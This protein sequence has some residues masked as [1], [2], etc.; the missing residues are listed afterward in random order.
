MTHPSLQALAS[1]LARRDIA[2]LRYQFPYM[3]R[4]SRRPDPPALCQATVRSAVAEAARLAPHLPLFAG[5]RSFGGRMSSAAQALSPLP[6]V[7]GLVFL[8]FPLHPAG[9]PGSER[10]T[11]LSKLTLPLLF[12]QGTRDALAQKALLEPLIERL[13]T[14]ASVHWLQG[15]DHGFHVAA[16]SGRTD[17]D[18]REEYVEVL[19][20]WLERIARGAP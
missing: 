8:A 12:I 3:E 4:G 7:R 10:A 1:A 17:T 20:R 15:A 9:R 5:G 14:R 11:H 19:S 2:T 6:Q 13:G 18:V 16:R